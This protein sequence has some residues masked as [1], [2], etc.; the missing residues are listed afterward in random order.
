MRLFF[1]LCFT[2]SMTFMGLQSLAHGQKT[3]GEYNY[4]LEQAIDEVAR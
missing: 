1:I 4:K 2:A 3:V